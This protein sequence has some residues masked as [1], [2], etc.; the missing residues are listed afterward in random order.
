MKKFMILKHEGRQPDV[1][2]ILTDIY[3][4]L[5]ENFVD[6][7]KRVTEIDWKVYSGLE[8]ESQ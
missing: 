4:V 6:H 3:K 1:S 8:I 2:C 7:R 5:Q